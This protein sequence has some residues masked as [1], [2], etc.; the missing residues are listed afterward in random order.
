MSCVLFCL[1]VVNQSYVTLET[2]SL[3]RPTTSAPDMS[4]NM[5][6]EHGLNMGP[7]HVVQ[8]GPDQLAAVIVAG[9]KS[10]WCISLV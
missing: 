10:L 4:D 6:L 5:G 3:P 8:M 9:L 2:A 1:A 7:E